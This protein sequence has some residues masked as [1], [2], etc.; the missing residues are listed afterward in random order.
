MKFQ[1]K[2][3]K[4]RAW[5]LTL[6]FFLN[7]RTMRRIVTFSSDC[8]YW[9]DGEDFQD[10]NKLFGLGYLWNH[11]KESARF[12]WRYDNA[13]SIIL[14][15]YCYVAGVRVIKDLCKV[16]FNT[17]VTCA[18]YVKRDFY[19]FDVLIDGAPQANEYIMKN[20]SKK[21]AY[22]LGLYFGGNQVAPKTMHVEIKTA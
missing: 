16:P 15:A 14:S 3:G 22:R 1:I 12:G 6:G 18:L 13:Q 2:K 11:H 19:V 8:A 5:P 10:T 9:L 7:R 17:R 20:H 4:H 21:F